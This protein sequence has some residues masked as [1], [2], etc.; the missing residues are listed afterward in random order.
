[1]VVLQFHVSPD[2]MR[3]IRLEAERTGKT[4]SELSR[5]YLRKGKLKSLEER[6][7]DSLAKTGATV[8]SCVVFYAVLWLGMNLIWIVAG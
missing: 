4:I 3:E 7:M 8:V 2:E 5:E 1:M 6:R